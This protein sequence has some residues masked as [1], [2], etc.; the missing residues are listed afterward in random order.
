MVEEGRD[1]CE[2]NLKGMLWPGSQSVVG[3]EDTTCTE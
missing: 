3:T 2:A 1:S